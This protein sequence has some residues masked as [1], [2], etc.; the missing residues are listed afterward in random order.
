MKT[1]EIIMAKYDENYFKFDNNEVPSEFDINSLLGK[2]E[3]KLWYG[4]PKK[5]AYMLA[6]ILKMFPIALLWMCFDG[7][8]IY[9]ISQNIKDIPIPV[10]IFLCFFFLF[11]LLPVWIWL[12]NII[13]ASKKHKNLEYMFTDKRIIIKTGVVGIDIENIY[14]ADIEGV[15][16]KVGLVDKILKVGD[17]YITSGEKA[18]VLWDIA[19]PYGIAN[20]L[21]KMILDIKSD[22]HYP[23]AL[24]PKENRGY[25]T[26]YVSENYEYQDTDGHN[27]SEQNYNDG[28]Y[29]DDDN[30]F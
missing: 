26:S 30:Q 17:I 2:N 6:S 20:K 28:N 21:Q 22:I 3:T 24:R 12:Y 7:F 25:N 10:I 1:Q 19:N 29:N 5:S 13:T 27:Y 14:Y 16:V 11:H 8:A 9:M 4:K 18:Q 23:N 15:N